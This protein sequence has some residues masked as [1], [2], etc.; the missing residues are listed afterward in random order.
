M[1]KMTRL[2][3][4]KFDRAASDGTNMIFLD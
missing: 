2:A 3:K 1:R 4:A